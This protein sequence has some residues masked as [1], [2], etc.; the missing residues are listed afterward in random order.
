MAHAAYVAATSDKLITALTNY[1]KCEALGYVPGKCNRSDFEQY[2]NPY[3]T[4]IS[5]TLIG[6]IPLG[7]LNFVLKWMSVKEAVVK[8]FCQLTRKFSKNV[9]LSSFSTA[10]S[11]ASGVNQHL[12]SNSILT[13]TKE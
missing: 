12:H 7:I 6:L 5:Y 4:L 9:N 11:G 1:F 2:N 10:K 3:I 13:N 8:L